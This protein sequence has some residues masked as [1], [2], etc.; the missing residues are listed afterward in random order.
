MST[1]STLPK[2]PADQSEQRPPV[3]KTSP[4]SKIPP[5]SIEI[6]EY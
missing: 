1:H 2:T 5:N 4:D 3:N 6:K